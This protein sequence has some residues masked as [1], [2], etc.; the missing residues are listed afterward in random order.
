MLPFPSCSLF[1]QGWAYSLAV[2]F[3]EPVS[4]PVWALLLGL[5]LFI[6]MLKKHIHRHDFC[7][8]SLKR[9]CHLTFLI[10]SMEVDTFFFKRSIVLILPQMDLKHFV[11]Y[12]IKLNVNIYKNQLRALKSGDE[13]KKFHNFHMLKKIICALFDPYLGIK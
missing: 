8:K 11:Q 2:V 5:G 13:I 3:C 7:L 10:F 6:V 4:V 12:R 9:I 1:S